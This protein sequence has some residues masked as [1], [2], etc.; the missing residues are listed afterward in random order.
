LPAGERK[1]T[2]IVF[3]DRDIVQ[4][5]S[6]VD[7]VVTVPLKLMMVLIHPCKLLGLPLPLLLEEMMMVVGR[8]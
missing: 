3:P 7:I 1:R 8:L 4:S 5:E 2:G 6:V